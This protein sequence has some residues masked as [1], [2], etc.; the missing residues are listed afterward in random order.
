MPNKFGV[1]R[2]M[3]VERE[4]KRLPPANLL[5]IAENSMAMAARYQPGTSE[6]P[7]Q[8]HSGLIG[9]VGAQRRSS[10]LFAEAARYCDGNA[11]ERGRAGGACRP[12]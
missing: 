8:Q 4:G 6:K 9:R 1:Q 11:A 5:V 7:N 12:A 2:A 10:V 3:A